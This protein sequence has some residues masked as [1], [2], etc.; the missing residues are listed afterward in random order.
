MN[1]GSSE[2]CCVNN[3]PTQLILPIDAH[4][5]KTIIVDLVIWYNLFYIENVM[6]VG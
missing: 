4:Y 2:P 5:L 3:G 6:E 1:V